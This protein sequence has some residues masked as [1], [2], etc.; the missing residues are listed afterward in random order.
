MIQMWL[1]LQVRFESKLSTHRQIKSALMEIF[2]TANW[3][4]QSQ[5]PRK[6][7]V[8]YKTEKFE[9]GTCQW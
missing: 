4:L 7:N 1:I 5:K 6:C 3:K 8:Q 9:V 2:I